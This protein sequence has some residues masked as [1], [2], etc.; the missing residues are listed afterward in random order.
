MSARLNVWEV[1]QSRISKTG[2]NR[3]ATV[4]YGVTLHPGAN[5]HISAEAKGFDAMGTETW[6]GLGTSSTNLRRVVP[7]GNVIAYPAI[8][9]LN[10]GP[11]LAPPVDWTC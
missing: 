6:Y 4:G 9:V 2:W 11:A 1:Q 8:K 5:A 7:W 3:E 10:I